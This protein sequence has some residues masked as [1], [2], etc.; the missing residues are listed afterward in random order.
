MLDILFKFSDSLSQ[1]VHVDVELGSMMV[2]IRDGWPRGFDLFPYRRLAY[3]L[4]CGRPVLT[5]PPPFCHNADA[6]TVCTVTPSSSNVFL[7]LV[8]IVD[9]FPSVFAP[10]VQSLN[11]TALG[12]V[13][14]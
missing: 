12:G 14:P 9:R 11:L 13:A 6:D 10:S 2:A 4:S 5:V 3:G 1:V 8:R 7:G